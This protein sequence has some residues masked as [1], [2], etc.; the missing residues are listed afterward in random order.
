MKK[1]LLAILLIFAF[2][3]VGAAAIKDSPGGF[4]G[5]RW[6]QSPAALGKNAVGLQMSGDVR[7]YLRTDDNLKIGGANVESI[8]YAF[9]ENKFLQVIIKAKGVMNGQLLKAAMI[10]RYGQPDIQSDSADY[11]YLWLDDKAFI[12][13]TYDAGASEA[14]ASIA[15]TRLMQAMIDR[16]ES[17]AK[18][19]IKDF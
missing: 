13:Y 7:G 5:I 2:C 11:S 1:T 19:G 12:K 18:R 4:R 6:G 9:W 15:S 17:E 8:R 10:A 16:Q 3:S 14:T